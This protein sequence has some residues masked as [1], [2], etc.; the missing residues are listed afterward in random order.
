MHT[1]LDRSK[2]QLK[3]EN[4]GAPYYIDYRVMELDG[5]NAEA[6]Y[7]AIRTN[8]Q[9]RQRY[10]RVVVRVGSYK[11]D[12]LYGQG[13]GTL[14]IL[15]LDDDM[16]TLRH[17]IWLA[18]DRAYKAATEALTEKQAHL[19]NFTVDQ[20]VD[21]FAQ[22]D[23]VHSVGPLVHLQLDP[24]PWLKLLQ[25]ASA[26]GKSDSQVQSFN[27]WV[28]FRAVNRYF[29][30]SEGTE[31]RDGRALY[32]LGIAGSSQA[33]DGMRLDRNWLFT[34]GDL[35]ELPSDKEFLDTGNKFISA[36]KE[37]R[38]APLVDEEYHG[39]VLMSSD[40][41]SD[42][43][44]QLVGENVLG[45]KPELGQSGRTRGAWA[46]NYKSRV[47]PDFIS[48]MDDPTLKSLD[49]KSLLGQYDV[50]DE[51][52]KPAA[53]KVI[54]N[55][56]L[57]NYLVGR[58]PIR[59]FPVSNGHGRARYPVNYPG[60][61]LGNLIVK[62][63]E[64][65]PHDQLKAKLIE[66][67]KQRE[68]PYGYFA[69]TLGPRNN[70]RLLYRVWVKDGHEELVRGAAFGDLDT[71]ALRNDLVAAGDDLNVENYSDPVPHSI[72][73]PSILFDELEV[74]RENVSKGKLP[75]YPAPPLVSAK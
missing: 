39:P 22:A 29:I 13:L 1:E 14:E 51:G 62:S 5:F 70:P 45:H 66:L 46:T 35:K 57:E 10:L 75:E 56:K 52:V 28:N 47:L 65:L 54:E 17:Q 7:G 16:Q 55:G 26:L 67:C 63:T 50:D 27:A 20:P 11:Q 49:G 44:L 2:A 25:T 30:D 60:P 37:L 12:S 23:P 68:L 15:P 24:Q 73:S 32:D 21:D 71:R 9:T 42:I 34:T 8:V 36:L 31:V 3:L 59:D 19:K 64:P 48:V 4:F 38:E 33:A 43:F 72:A 6:A 61:S 69:E 41:A 53:V 58:T 18:T 40:A 74:K